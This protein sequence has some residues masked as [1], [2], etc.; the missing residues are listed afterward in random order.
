M[1]DPPYDWDGHEALINNVLS[2]GLLK[3]DGVFVLEHGPENDFSEHPDV[4]QTR[5]YGSVN[6]AFFS[7]EKDD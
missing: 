1:A 5:K 7:L 6:F 2:K 4:F 3:K